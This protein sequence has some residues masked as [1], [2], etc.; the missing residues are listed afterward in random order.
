MICPLCRRKVEE[1]VFCPNDGAKLVDEKENVCKC[2]QCGKVYTDG[3]KFCVDDGKP[4]RDGLEEIALR[5]QEKKTK[6]RETSLSL[7]E[8]DPGVMWWKKR[9]GLF[10]NNDGNFVFSWNWPAFFVELFLGGPLWYF[11]KGMYAKGAI[12]FLGGVLLL[13]VSGGLANLFVLPFVYGIMS[14]YDYYLYVVKKES[15]WGRGGK[16]IDYAGNKRIG[17]FI[18]AAILLAPLAILALAGILIFIAARGSAVFS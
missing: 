10:N 2:S 4:V 13:F 17:K 18:I 15:L 3:T 16:D 14:S 7:M 6:E 8:A 11:A 1:G 9:F 5:E 12:Y